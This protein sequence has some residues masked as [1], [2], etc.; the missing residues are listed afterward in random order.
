MQVFLPELL[1]DVLAG[2][3]DPSPVLDLTVDLAGVPLGY[4]EM[5]QRQAMKRLCPKTFGCC[6]ITGRAQIV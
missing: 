5:D 4:A 1:A 2:R 3:L 6:C